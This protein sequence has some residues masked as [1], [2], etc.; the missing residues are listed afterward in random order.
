MAKTHHG[1]SLSHLCLDALH[2]RHD[3]RAVAGNSGPGDA[4]AEEARPIPADAGM[5]GGRL[6]DSESP[7]FLDL[8]RPLMRV[9]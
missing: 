9:I 1:T 8:K 5:C 7:I 6:G 4:D 2:L 3:S